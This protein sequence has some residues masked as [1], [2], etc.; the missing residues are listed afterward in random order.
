MIFNSLITQDIHQ[1]AKHYKKIFTDEQHKKGLAFII[2][3][4]FCFI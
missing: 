4:E 3:I 1:M 2:K